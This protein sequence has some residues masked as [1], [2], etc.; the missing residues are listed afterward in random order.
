MYRWTVAQVL[1]FVY[2]RTF[3]GHD[4]LMMMAAAPDVTFN[5]PGSNSFAASLA[6]RESLQ[7]WLARFTA[8]S[9]TFDIRDIAVSGP[10]W[11]MTVAVRFHDAIGADYEN[12]G[13]EWLRI[14]WGRVRSLEVFLDTERVSAWEG[15]HAGVAGP[16]RGA[17]ETAIR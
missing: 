11:N 9:P 7:G 10:P 14:R 1:R 5:F 12:E 3:A 17:G 16:P 8:L 4:S 2:R 15:R 13:V 6:G